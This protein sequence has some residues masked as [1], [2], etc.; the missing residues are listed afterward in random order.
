[1]KAFVMSAGIGT[2]LRPLTYVV[3]KPMISVANKPVLEHT[4]ELLKS[5]RIKDVVI[6]LHFKPEI[7]EEYFKSGSGKGVKITYSREQKLMGTAG[8]VKKMESVL[9]DGTFLIM[10]GDGLTNVDLTELIKFHRKKKGIATI[11]LQSI[12]TRLEYGLAAVGKTGII[13]RFIEK[14]SWGEVF[15]GTNTGVNTGIYVFEPEVFKYMPRGREFDF[16]K[17]LFPA[18]MKNKKKIFAFFTDA[19]WCDIG[20]L[21]KYRQCQKDVL[22]GR[23]KVNI[24]GKFRRGAYIGN[25]CDIDAS[26]SF[27]GPAIIGNKCRIKADVEIG[28]CSVLGNNLFVDEGAVVND[29]IIWDNVYIGKGVRIENCI[30]GKNAR[31]IESISVSD[32][33][34]QVNE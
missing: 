17:E 32:G 31:V 27:S 1:M 24:E 13:D 8:G 3:P 2:R 25:G 15:S 11:V 12:D 6:N 10:S 30:I 28:G 29:C 16:A 23:A 26:V 34:I 19:Y 21:S 4:L 22:E 7:I 33:I 14:P 20:N 18:L 5:H 9:K